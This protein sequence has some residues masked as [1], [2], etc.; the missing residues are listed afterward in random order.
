M[1]KTIQRRSIDA[2]FQVRTNDDGTTGI[3]GYAAVFDS[4]AHGEV[5]KRSAFNRTLAQKDNVRLLF[6]HNPDK[7]FASTRQG[8]LTL[9]VDDHGLWFDAPS[10]D[11]ESPDVRSF[12]SAVGR[13][14]VYQ[15]SFAGYWRDDP[16]VSGVRELRECELI[17]VSGVTFPWYEETDMSI[18]GDRALDGQLVQTRSIGDPPELTP[19]QRALALRV[20]RAAPPGKT[21]YGDE[22]DK[23]WDAIEE[24]VRNLT[25]VADTWIYVVDWGTDWAVYCAFDWNTYDYGPYMQLSWK[26][27]TAGTFKLGDPFEVERVTEYRPVTTET[28]DRVTITVAEARAL[29][30]APAA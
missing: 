29:L 30:G 27:N 6:N 20:L 2:A 15:C 28:D 7:C 18:T 12:L 21:S 19:E 4:P 5:V 13:G 8:T 25:G 9:G 26:K 17:D 3:H 14:D 22:L 1:T 23:L 16:L 10:L 11:T 24:L